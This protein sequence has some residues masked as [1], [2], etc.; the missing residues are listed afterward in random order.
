MYV[1]INLLFCVHISD[2]YEECEDYQL[3]S[4]VGDTVSSADS[5]DDNK[6]VLRR[7]RR[8]AKKILPEDF[9]SSQDIHGM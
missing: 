2:S 5:D 8:R 6:G 4:A 7:K 1:K 3:T 9:V